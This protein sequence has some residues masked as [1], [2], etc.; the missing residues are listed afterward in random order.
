VI[1]IKNIL[2][3]R[4]IKNIYTLRR[5]GNA[6]FYLLHIKRFLLPVT[7][8]IYTYTLWGPRWAEDIMGVMAALLPV[9]YFPTSLIYP[10]T[11]RV[12]G[13]KTTP[14]FEIQKI[15]QGT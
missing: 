3:Y 11:L 10:C 4:L 14:R 6:F 12:R 2:L 13:I 8:F 7:Y 9:T 1:L 15:I 5:S